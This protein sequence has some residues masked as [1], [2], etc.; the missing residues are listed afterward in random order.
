MTAS[1]PKPLP[2]DA[3]Q[4]FADAV[5]RGLSASRKSLPS[6]Y[7]YDDRGDRI[8]Q[9]IMRS[10]DYYPT[11]AE[12]EILTEQAPTIAA[13]MAAEGPFE[14]VELGAGDG[15]KTRVL[16]KELLHCPARLC[17]VP[18]DI[19]GSVLSEL[20]SILAQEL[21]ELEVAPQRGDYFRAL[22][23]LDPEGPRRV[24]MF[25]GGNIGNFTLNDARSFLI[26]LRGHMRAEDALLIGIDLQKDPRVVLRAYDDRS[27][28]TRDFNLNL[29]RRINRELG[30]DF[31]L[32]AFAHYPTY[33][34][35]TGA[36]KSFL[37]SER[38]QSV[39]IE[40][41]G[42]RYDFNKGEVIYVEISLKYSP[43][44]IRELA[45]ESGFRI[46]ASNT[47]S[48]GW[49]VDQYWQ[50]LVSRRRSGQ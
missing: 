10:E 32:D 18:I 46:V 42:E 31:D 50:P 49:F 15:L 35:Q 29:L 28:H 13:E 20:K 9:A 22:A 4:R 2:E 34:P 40:A 11:R 33:D 7:F 37:I 26:E 27:G 8:F 36:A 6:R 21:P 19:S 3:R 23:R 39:E 44:M 30:A 41:T 45:G 48:N 5:D 25:L 24:F 47:D 1:S 17:Y 14:L 12:F 43:S 38:E 16:L